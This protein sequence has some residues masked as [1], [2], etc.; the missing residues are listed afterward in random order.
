MFIHCFVDG[1]DTDPKSG[2]GFV[3]DLQKHCAESA[4]K[5]ASVIG[6]YYAMDRDHRWERVREAYDLLVN[7]KGKPA[8]DMVK[9]IEESYAEGITDEFIKPIVS[10][11][12]DGRIGEAMCGDILQ[13]PQRP[14][15]GA[16]RRAVTQHEEG[17]HEAGGRT[18]V[19]L[20]DPY[21][22]SFKGVH[23]L[24]DKEDVADTL[25]EYLSKNR[26]RQLHIA[27]TEKY[28]HVTFFFNGG[29]EA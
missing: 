13:L 29:R 2:A 9:A 21:D 8:A 16:D 10:T 3:G 24:F 27:E 20:H 7:G 17:G 15:E 26:L 28:A 1:R 14:R 23:I 12:V 11:E 22:A 25:A 4:G 18:P 5:V 6:R 19:L